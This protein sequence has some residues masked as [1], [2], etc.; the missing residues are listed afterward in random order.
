MAYGDDPPCRRSLPAD[1]SLKRALLGPRESWKL[2]GTLQHAPPPPP[3]KISPC[4]DRSYVG[5]SL[6]GQAPWKGV[7]WPGMS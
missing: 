1:E 4:W 5:S 2:E 6:V 3:I 7:S